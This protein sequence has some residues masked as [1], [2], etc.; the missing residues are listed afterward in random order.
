MVPP[1]PNPRLRR[2]LPGK[3]RCP[4]NRRR[5]FASNLRP[6]PQRHQKGNP[7]PCQTI[8]RQNNSHQSRHPQPISSNRPLQSS[9]RSAPAIFSATKNCV[10]W[11][12]SCVT[13]SVRRKLGPKRCKLSGSIFVV[14]SRCG[15]DFSPIPRTEKGW[16]L[17]G[18]S[19]SLFPTLGRFGRVYT[20]P[21]GNW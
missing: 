10:I 16:L 4:N 12:S 7:N 2:H 11:A 3:R 20:S 9:M 8:L 15:F 6:H 5:S 19:L 1:H 14:S 17:K 21:F 13:S 18:V